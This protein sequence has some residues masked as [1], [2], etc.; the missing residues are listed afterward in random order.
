MVRVTGFFAKETMWKV[1]HGVTIYL[2][3]GTDL[4]CRFTHR[5]KSYG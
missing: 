3:F 5:S 4:E 1:A 2:D